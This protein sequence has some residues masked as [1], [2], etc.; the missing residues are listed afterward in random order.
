MRRGVEASIDL[1]ALVPG[2]KDARICVA[3][4][5]PD[6]YLHGTRGQLREFARQIVEKAD[7]VFAG[8]SGSGIETHGV[9]Q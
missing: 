8:A 6:V 9:V 4:Y 5:D 3:F 7:W 1:Q 2:D